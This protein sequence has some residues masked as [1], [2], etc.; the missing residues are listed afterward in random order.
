MLT[1]KQAL[2][3]AYTILDDLYDQ[4]KSGTLVGLL[5]DMNPFVFT[6][7]TPADPATWKEWITCSEKV[8]KGG[9]LTEDNAFQTLVSFLHFNEE[10][11]GYR[12]TWILDNIQTLA[13][14]KRWSQLIEKAAALKD[15]Q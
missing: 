14:Q 1:Y 9:A 2:L 4:T 7:R 15:E 5:S 3:A 11:Y 8:Q 12:A 10:Q 13:Y 6:D